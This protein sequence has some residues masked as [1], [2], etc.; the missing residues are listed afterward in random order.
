MNTNDLPSN[1]QNVALPSS[2]VRGLSIVIKAS[3]AFTLA[4]FEV[5]G[6]T[7]KRE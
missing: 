7:N 6:L 4:D 5:Y 2:L 1:Y 3:D